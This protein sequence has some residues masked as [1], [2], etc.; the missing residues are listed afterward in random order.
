VI[1]GTSYNNSYFEISLNYRVGLSLESWY[2]YSYQHRGYIIFCSEWTCSGNI[3]HLV[4]PDISINQKHGMPN[5]LTNEK[6]R[7]G[8]Q[9]LKNK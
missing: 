6:I 1:D 9:C 5:T 4:G 2:L 8:F 3:F 7:T